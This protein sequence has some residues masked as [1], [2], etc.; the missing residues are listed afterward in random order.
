MDIMTGKALAGKPF[1]R[2][3]PFYRAEMIF[4]LSL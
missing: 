1:K 2:A 4:K 3:C